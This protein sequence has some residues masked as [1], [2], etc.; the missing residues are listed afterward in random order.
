MNDPTITKFLLDRGAK[1]VS[2][3][4][5]RSALS[6]AAGRGNVHVVRLLLNHADDADLANSH[7]AL[8]WAAA[9]GREDVVKLLI[10]HGFDV[11]RVI[12]NCSMGETPLL[13]TCEVG[14][15][16]SERLEV[17]KLLIKEGADVHARGREGKTAAEKLLH[18]NE[19]SGL[20]CNDVE[21]RQLLAATSP[22]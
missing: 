21:L 20:L 17:A 7:E 6:S 5:Q 12:S 13:A 18:N 14:K 8:H 22:R 15:L 19:P 10:E 11:N 1:I 3:A 2:A 16:D 9:G 4:G